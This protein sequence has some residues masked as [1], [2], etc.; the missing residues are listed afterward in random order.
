MIAVRARVPLLLAC[1]AAPLGAS[2]PALA[3]DTDS[4]ANNG[5][6]IEEVVVVG[7][8]IRRRE[9][10]EGRAP[11]QT[12]A[13]ALFESVGAAQGVDILPS[14]TANTGSYLA[15]QQNYL[16]ASRSSAC[17]VWACLPR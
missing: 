6:A 16:R 8:L 15:T 5:P 12:L 7:S 9:V 3:Q 1:L 14:L 4:K 13:A 2:V 11:V 17:A 10:Y